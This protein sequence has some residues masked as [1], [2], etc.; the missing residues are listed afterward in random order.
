VTDNDCR[1]VQNLIHDMFRMVLASVVDSCD[2]L[3][4]ILFA[5]CCVLVLLNLFMSFHMEYHNW[6]FILNIFHVCSTKTIIK[7]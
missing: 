3:P 7:F 1:A 4:V 5:G 6:V 2:F